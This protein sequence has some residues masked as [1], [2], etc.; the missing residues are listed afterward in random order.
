MNARSSSINA[1]KSQGYVS[2]GKRAQT[3]SKMVRAAANRLAN[4]RERWLVGFVRVTH[5]DGEAR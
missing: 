5:G 4:L 1:I 2:G 3:A